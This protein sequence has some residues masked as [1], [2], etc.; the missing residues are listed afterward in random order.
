MNEKKKRWL[1]ISIAIGVLLILY[2]LKNSSMFVRVAGFVIGFLIFYFLDTFF[3]INFQPKHY[4]YILIILT[5]GILLAPLYFLS[6]NYDKILH[7]V[8]PILG[9]TLIFYMINNQRLNFQWK[10]LITFMFILSFLT[11]HEI[12]E[13]LIDLLWDFKLQGVYIRDF[14]GIEKLNLTMSKIDDTMIDLIMGTLGGIVFV[15]GKT[16]PYLWK[17]KKR[18]EK[19]K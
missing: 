1:I 7:L 4:L 11:L 3:K 17:K 5:S 8:S 18:S 19:K 16:I 14:S 15:I 2:F 12:G 9:S 6:E 13:Y 10:L